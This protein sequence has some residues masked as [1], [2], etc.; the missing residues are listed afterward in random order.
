M[1]YRPRTPRTIQARDVAL[2]QLRDAGPGVFLSTTRLVVGTVHRAAHPDAVRRAWPTLA[3]F[4]GVLVRMENAGEVI[5]RVDGQVH[6]WALGP[7]APASVD[8]SEFELLL[9][10]L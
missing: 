10:E 2:A 5:R 6:W 3:V 7:E 9:E 4:H 1:G 8:M